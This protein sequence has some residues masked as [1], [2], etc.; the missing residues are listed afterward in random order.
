MKR[1][2]F[3]L[4][5]LLV[6]IAIIAILIG[7]L[8]PAVQKVREAA[9][10]AK[11]SN[12]LKQLGIAMHS[13]HDQQQKLPAKTGSQGQCCWG[14]WIIMILP[15]IEQQAMYQLYQN[16]GGNDSIKNDFPAAVTVTPFPR[17]GGPPNNTNVTTRRLTTLTCP[18]DR[19]NAPISN[20]T[21]HNYAVIAG[22]GASHWGFN[23]NPVAGPTPL[24]TLTTPYVARAGMFDPGITEFVFVGTAVQ[25]NSKKT[26]LTDVTDGLS[27]TLMIGENR[28]G[29]G[30]DLRGFIWWGDAAS[31]STYY[32]PNTKSNDVISQNCNNDVQGGLPCNNGSPVTLALR[33]KHTGGVNVCLGDASVR[34]VRD[35]IDM[36]VWV[37]SGS[38][39]DG[40]VA[41]L[42]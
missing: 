28:Q 11:C 40:V 39:A 22:N 3:T 16:Y 13:F 30:S 19:E 36:N 37:W 9:A 14:T 24:P 38:A 20:L 29:T 27:N 32:A 12:N 25:A 42:N 4:I 17:Y 34:F 2:G 35:S 10:R 23:G 15:H 5:E 8:L 7:L 41:T 26:K 18:S 6:V 31:L 1:R 33:S 21:N